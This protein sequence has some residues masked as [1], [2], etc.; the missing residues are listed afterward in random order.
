VR[1]IRLSRFGA[2][3]ELGD[4]SDTSAVELVTSAASLELEL[5]VPEPSALALPALAI[6]SLM[7]TRQ[8]FG[9]TGPL[10]ESTV[11]GARVGVGGRDTV[12]D[13]TSLGLSGLR[14]AQVERIRLTDRGIGFTVAGAVERITIGGKPM[15]LSSRF[16]WLEREQAWSLRI[17]LLAWVLM[18]LAGVVFWR[19]TNVSSTTAN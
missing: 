2:P 10:L 16:R 7:L 3:A 1:R 17:G 19:T 9:D 8:G 5:R 4:Y 6:D 13:A 12:L 15:G 11:L 18:L 14:G